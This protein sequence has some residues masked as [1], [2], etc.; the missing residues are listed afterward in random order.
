MLQQ[1]DLA[2]DYL[3]DFLFLLSE[4]AVDLVVYIVLPHSGGVLLCC[5]LAVLQNSVNRLQFV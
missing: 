4:C 3:P 2:L 1:S 5:Y